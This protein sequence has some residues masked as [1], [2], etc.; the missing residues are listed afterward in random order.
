MKDDDSSKNNQATSK[1]DPPSLTDVVNPEISKPSVSDTTG[2][3][4]EENAEQA[5]IHNEKGGQQAS[6]TET[7]LIKSIGITDR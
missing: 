1:N 7:A 4:I 2:K 5:S 6:P 3:V